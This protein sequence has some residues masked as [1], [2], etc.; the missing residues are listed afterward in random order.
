MREPPAGSQTILRSATHTIHIT[1]KN[2]NVTLI[3]VVNSEGDMVIAGMRAGGVP[4]V[5][6]VD[7]QLQVANGEAQNPSGLQTRAG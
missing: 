1:V 6:G 5:F 3:G 2:G 7:N 4:A